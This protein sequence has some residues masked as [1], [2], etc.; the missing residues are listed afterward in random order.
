VEQQRRTPAQPVVE[1]A[2]IPASPSALRGSGAAP[3][4][5]EAKGSGPALICRFQQFDSSRSGQLGASDLRRLLAKDSMLDPREDCVKMVRRVTSRVIQ[6]TLAAN[7]Y[8]PTRPIP[9]TT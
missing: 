3:D 9:L 1:Q 5:S 6:L 8:V 7:E 4:V 2:A